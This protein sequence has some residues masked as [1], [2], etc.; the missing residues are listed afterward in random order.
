[1]FG[2]LKKRQPY[3][4]R[5]AFFAYRHFCCCWFRIDLH[6]FETFFCRRHFINVFNC[7]CNSKMPTETESRNIIKSILNVRCREGATIADIQSK[8]L[9]ILS[10][11]SLLFINL[12]DHC[13]STFQNNQLHFFVFNFFWKDDYGEVV[14]RPLPDIDN[15]LNSIECAYSI[16]NSDGGP[17]WYVRSENMQH[18]TKLIMEQKTPQSRPYRPQKA[19]RQSIKENSHVEEC[20]FKD[21]IVYKHMR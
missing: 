20:Y 13:W 4:A 14:G 9:G 8:W 2:S 5:G 1:M 18:L 11:L 10:W 3:S 6:I 19:A 17:K 15:F 7:D 12:K 21:N 16:N